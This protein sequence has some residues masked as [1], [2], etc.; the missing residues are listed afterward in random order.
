MIATARTTEI[1]ETTG[2]PPEPADCAAVLRAIELMHRRAGEPLSLADLARAAYTS[3]YHFLRT[4]TRVTGLSPGRFLAAIR[5]KRAVR[6]LLSTDLPVTE[7]C[8][9]CGYQSLG[10]FTRRF[11]EAIGVAPGR[12]RLPGG[13][14]LPGRGARPEPAAG[15]AALHGRVAW[16]AERGPLEL[17]FVGLFA[18][19][20]PQGFPAACA[21]LEAPGPFALERVAD[22]VYHLVAAGVS[23]AEELWECF[24]R[25][26]PDFLAGSL[27][28]EVVVEGGIARGTTDLVLRR[29]R[30]TDPPLLA[31]L[32]LL[33]GRLAR[34]GHP[35]ESNPGEAGV[36][37]AAVGLPTIPSGRARSL[38][39][40][41]RNG[42]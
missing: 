30:P 32:P 41:R 25:D 24:L 23:S 22:G 13:L 18:S 9:E 17:V 4:F 12:L 15:A 34:E 1:L 42:P 31:C 11:S 40:S 35:E 10:T 33:L 39:S 27:V 21:L 19:R 16:G 26:H 29:P 28:E 5:M 14:A 36:A 7:V 6:L 20:A 37:A 2:A 8:Y 38:E 3:P